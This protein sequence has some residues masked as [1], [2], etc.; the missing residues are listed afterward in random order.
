MGSPSVEVLSRHY[1]LGGSSVRKEARV[2]IC[3]CCMSGM[4]T[5]RLTWVYRNETDLYL[6]SK[7]ESVLYSCV[8]H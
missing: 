1:A 8:R 2:R 7:S 6:K 3:M 4:I 5:N